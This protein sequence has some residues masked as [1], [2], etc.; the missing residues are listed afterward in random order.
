[1]LEG[2]VY[3]TSDALKRRALQQT[4]DQD[5]Q[6]IHIH[7]HRDDPAMPQPDTE[8]YGEK[9]IPD[10]RQFLPRNRDD[11]LG[12]INKTAEGI[13]S[14]SEL[15]EHNRPDKVTQDGQT[16]TQVA[17]LDP[18]PDGGHYELRELEDGSYEVVLIAE[19]ESDQTYPN[20]S[21]GGA[22][23][24]EWST[25]DS[26]VHRLHTSGDAMLRHQNN[27]NRRFW[28]N[29][30]G[31]RQRSKT[32]DQETNGPN[33]S[34]ETTLLQQYVG[35]G[36]RLVLKE[37]GDGWA[38]VVLVSKNTNSMSGS[39][40]REAY[41]EGPSVQSTSIPSGGSTNDRANYNL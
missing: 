29:S 8:T 23:Q 5:N 13:S 7:L 14:T 12:T 40:P 38:D 26:N 19:A 34:M 27:L 15:V 3:E 22:A 31:K 30:Q 36:Q 25:A 2:K 41:G 6:E 33:G 16:T 24:G 10:R 11:L 28:A 1:M 35:S 9:F 4:K 39:V 37:R 21:T 18:L 17:T 20:Q 32:K